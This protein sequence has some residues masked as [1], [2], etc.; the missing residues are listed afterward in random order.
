[1]R[2]FYFDEIQQWYVVFLKRA[3][4]RTRFIHWLVCDDFAHVV[5]ARETPDGRTLL[6]DPEEWGCA[7]AFV[8]MP[9]EDF[10]VQLDP[11]ASAIL[12]YM[13]DYRRCVQYRFRGIYTCVTICKTILGVWGC[14]GILP[15]HLY[16]FLLRRAH[17][18]VV[19]GFIPYLPKVGIV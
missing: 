13:A 1:M 12:S 17:T 9:I 18:T 5:M 6:V 19:K 10:I 11:K 4:P 15:K 16:R 3:K 8:D 14:W 2:D 7:L